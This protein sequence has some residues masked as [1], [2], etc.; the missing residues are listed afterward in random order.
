MTIL[1]RAATRIGFPVVL[2]A[3]GIAH[4]TEAGA[5]VLNLGSAGAVTEAARKVDEEVQERMGGLGGG[6]GGMPG[7]G[8]LFG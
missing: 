5:V 2:K 7:L 1:R 4:K 8:G 3:E 6:L